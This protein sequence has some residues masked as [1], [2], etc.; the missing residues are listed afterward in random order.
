MTHAWLV[1]LRIPEIAAISRPAAVHRWCSWPAE[2]NFGG[3]SWSPRHFE[4]GDVSRGADRTAPVTL[5]MPLSD[6]EIRTFWLSA[7]GYLDA[8]VILVHR[9]RTGWQESVRVRGRVGQPQVDADVAVVPLDPS[10]PARETGEV[11][12][13]QAQVALHPGDAGFAQLES[14]EAVEPW[15]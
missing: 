9:A 14:Q 15:P 7:P 2:V 5:S 10:Q 6:A 8:T 3:Q 1:E 13:H 4:I 12:S 11:W